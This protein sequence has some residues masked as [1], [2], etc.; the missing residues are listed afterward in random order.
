MRNCDHRMA[1]NLQ[2]I[3][4]QIVWGDQT[5][6]QCD[7]NESANEPTLSGCS[8]V[9]SL[10]ETMCASTRARTNIHTLYSVYMAYRLMGVC[11]Y[12]CVCVKRID[13]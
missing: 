5:N 1:T 11:M 13:G 6:T 12:V 9:R 7:K 3:K 2:Y 8:L 10:L 4:R